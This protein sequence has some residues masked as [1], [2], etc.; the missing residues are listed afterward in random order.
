MT[1]TP[2]AVFGVPLAQSLSNAGQ[3][4]NEVPAVVDA[5]ITALLALPSLPDGFSI[6]LSNDYQ[7]V[8]NVR[9]QA[10]DCESPELSGL[11]A[12]E[13]VDVVRMFVSALPAALIPADTA[14]AMI[15]LTTTAP[16]TGRADKYRYLLGTLAPA[17]RALLTRILEAIRRM[18]KAPGVSMANAV[19]AF[20]PAFIRDPESSTLSKLRLDAL[21]PLV[22]VLAGEYASLFST[23]VEGSVEYVSF[24]VTRATLVPFSSSFLAADASD[25]VFIMRQ[26]GN[27]PLWY[28]ESSSGA[29]HFPPAAVQVVGFLP[30]LHGSAAAA[31]RPKAVTSNATALRGAPLTISIGGKTVYNGAIQHSSAFKEAMAS[32]SP[33]IAITLVTG[34]TTSL[35]AV[36]D[37]AVLEH[38]MRLVVED[39]LLHAVTAMD[40]AMPAG[41]ALS[42]AVTTEAGPSTVLM[43]V[44]KGSKL[45][46][47]NGALATA[48][49]VPAGLCETTV[50]EVSSTTAGESDALQLE[51]DV[52]DA[53]FAFAVTGRAA[54]VEPAGASTATAAAGGSGT[55]AGA[56]AA[57]TGAGASAANSTGASSSGASAGGDGGDDGGE[58]TYGGAPIILQI[59]FR[60]GSYKK[61][62]STSETPCFE[63]VAKIASNRAAKAEAYTLALVAA[64]SDTPF[65]YLGDEDLPSAVLKSKPGSRLMF[66]RKLQRSGD[67]AVNVREL[68]RKSSVSIVQVFYEDHYSSFRC[69]PA[70]TAAELAEQVMRKPV[71][72]GKD[73]SAYALYEKVGEL[74][75]QLEPSELPSDL[76]T[77]YQSEGVVVQFVL[78]HK[79]LEL[80]EYAFIEERTRKEKVKLEDFD[81]LK[82]IG[83]GGY[84]KVCQVQKKDTGGIYAM[85]II[86]KA[87]IVKEKDLLHT[88][89]EQRILASIKH[90]FLLHLQY[91]FQ[92]PE[93]L[94]LVMDY[95][96]GGELFFHLSNEGF[97]PEEQAKFYTAE[98]VLALDHLHSHNILYRDLKPENVL[99]DAEGHV[100][101]CDFGLCKATAS[102]TG[103]LC[104]T[105]E[106]LAPEML[107]GEGYGPE[108]DWWEVGVLMYE[109]RTGAPPFVAEEG[110]SQV[111]LFRKV[112]Y[113][114]PPV[115]PAVFSDNAA[116]LLLGLM[117]KDPSQRLGSNSVEDIKSHPFFACYDWDALYNRQIEPPF[118][119]N[120]ADA[121]STA[122]VDEEFLNMSVADTLVEPSELSSVV[123]GSAFDGFSY[124]ADSAFNN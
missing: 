101:L 43:Y 34:E 49:G 71:F 20:G 16:S 51:A 30:P 119:P 23:P 62:K 88:K 116:S 21:Q 93:K 5:A 115:D 76:F 3:A 121:S 39:S 25:V 102:T 74:Q 69:S 104:G 60:E 45:V 80:G 72:A 65:K 8:Q 38:K 82:V 118:K 37:N 1:G 48:F 68:N 52:P 44:P 113:S 124:V 63:V 96:N 7:S 61:L 59:W 22:A 99:L 24:G 32:A 12:S 6:S 26:A 85:K 54:A 40:P 73:L 81:L 83:R 17:E 79:T 28:G 110:E 2:F 106:Y 47:V 122:N 105:A 67:A 35:L 91:S 120:V 117:E 14:K 4:P 75:R 100:R 53:Q 55:G 84:G 78:R 33:S 57:A 90:P 86:S 27:A 15:L 19:A 42:I 29:G 10:D 13:L 9:M 56:S 11:S 95:I 77:K 107:K 46:H 98:L 112:L 50:G 70:T 89:E 66:V 87:S 92:T 108:V 31:P 109:M 36:G 18:V 111:D 97:F 103:T 94:Y 64:K 58:A 41:A 114:N 123:Q